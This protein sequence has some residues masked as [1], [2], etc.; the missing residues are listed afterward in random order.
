VAA[1]QIFDS[2]AGVLGEKEFE[3]WSIAPI[4]ANRAARVAPKAGCPYHRLPQG[5]WSAGG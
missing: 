1:V 5:G 4:A 3:R 2:W